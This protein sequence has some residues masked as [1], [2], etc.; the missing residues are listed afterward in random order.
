MK[1]LNLLLILFLSACSGSDDIEDVKAENKEEYTKEIYLIETANDIRKIRSLQDKLIVHLAKEEEP[2]NVAITFMDMSI[3]ASDQSYKLP[4]T[5]SI[6]F[7]L[8]KE[9]LQEVQSFV[10]EKY[11]VFSVQKELDRLALNEAITKLESLIDKL[12]SDFKLVK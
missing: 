6:E 10:D 9:D 1:K 5:E 2:V 3:A 11:K 12:E 4:G 8:I 7:D